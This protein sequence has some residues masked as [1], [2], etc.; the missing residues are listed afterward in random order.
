MDKILPT[1]DTANAF[2]HAN[3][4]LLDSLLCLSVTIFAFL[5]P[6]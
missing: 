6:S 4:C 1:F 2:L 5:I 3:S